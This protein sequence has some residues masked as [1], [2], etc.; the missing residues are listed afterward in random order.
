MPCCNRM[1]SHA[2]SLLSPSSTQQKEM[3]SELRSSC[4]S[5]MPSN[6]AC[7]SW[8]T[9]VEPPA[10]PDGDALLVER[11]QT[12]RPATTMRETSAAL[13]GDAEPSNFCNTSRERC[14]GFPVKDWGSR[15]AAIEALKMLGGIAGYL[16][17]SDLTLH[18]LDLPE[19]CPAP[20]DF[21]E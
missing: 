20:I 19:I 14:K 5:V 10:V 15:V 16:F 21:E 2:A 4:G 1:R 3:C 18:A 17:R 12:E 6:R 9:A 13:S 8:S 11:T 7:R